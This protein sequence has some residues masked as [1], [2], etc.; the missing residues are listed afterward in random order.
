MLGDFHRRWAYAVLLLIFISGTAHFLLHQYFQAS[1]P[2][3]P[4][5]NPA[6]PWLLRLHGAAA[7][8]SLVLLGSL[9]PLHILRFW[10]TARRSRTA[11]VFLG[12]AILLIVSGYGLYYLG[13]EWWRSA[14]RIAHI[15]LGLAALP[16]FFLHLRKGRR[17][18]PRA[19]RSYLAD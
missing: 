9:L 1:G 3:G 2:F 11:V 14:C 8:A 4:Q 7:M 15:A 6:E 18:R 16:A 12:I 19:A 5:P 10:R 13:G 17:S